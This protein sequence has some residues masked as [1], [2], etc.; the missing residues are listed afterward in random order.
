MNEINTNNNKQMKKKIVKPEVKVM[1]LQKMNVIAT[2]GG[3]T[4]V[5]PTMTLSGGTYMGDTWYK[6]ESE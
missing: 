6:H 2:S 3:D 4:D 1:K 5:T